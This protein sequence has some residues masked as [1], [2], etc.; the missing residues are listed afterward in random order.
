MVSLIPEECLDKIRMLYGKEFDS[1]DELEVLA[2]VTAY[3]EG[4]VTNLRLQTICNNHPNDIT[5]VLYGLVQ[6]ELL[7]AEGY[8]RGSV[9]HINEDFDKESSSINIDTEQLIEDERPV[10]EFM[11]SNGFINRSLSEKNLGFTKNKNLKVC[12]SLIKKGFIKK[13][14][15]SNKVAYVLIDFDENGAS[16]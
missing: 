7:V 3:L 2:I 15:T 9:Y 4:C 5:K 6:K 10:L 16:L 11:R 8:G 12:N 13:I 1:L 14:A